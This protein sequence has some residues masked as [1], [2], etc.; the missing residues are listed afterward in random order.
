MRYVSRKRLAE[1]RPRVRGQFVRAEVAAACRALAAVQVLRGT[2]RCD[3]LLPVGLDSGTGPPVGSPLGR[4]LRDQTRCSAL[5][6]VKGS[7]LQSSAGLL[8]GQQAAAAAALHKVTA[9]QV[10]AALISRFH[11][12]A[13]GW[14]ASSRRH[15]HRSS[16]SEK[17][18]AATLHS[19]MA[20]W[21]HTA[22]RTMSGKANNAGPI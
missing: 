17:Q 14:G 1:S 19:L 16:V 21:S 12:F 3:V 7:K 22:N 13:E 10:S 20:V 18:S 6:D 15:G 8:T 11:M 5:C 9:R 4:R 2:D